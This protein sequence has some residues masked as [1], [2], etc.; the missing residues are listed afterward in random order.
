VVMVLIGGKTV[1][2]LEDFY[3]ILVC[4]YLYANRAGFVLDYG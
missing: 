3:G 1:L 4:F 2:F